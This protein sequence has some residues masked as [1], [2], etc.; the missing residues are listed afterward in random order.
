MRRRASAVPASLSADD[1]VRDQRLRAITEAAESF[2][3]ALALGIA[4]R[5]PVF[6]TTVSREL[7]QRIRGALRPYLESGEQMRPDFGSHAQLRVEG[8][9]L[10]VTR[11]LRVDVEFEDRSIREL[12]DGRLTPVP[13]RVVHLALRVELDPCVIRSCSIRLEASDPGG[14]DA[15]S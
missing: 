7:A 5:D 15:R 14:L 9:L 11:P 13:R 1:A 8:D 6:E 3:Y 12:A 4:G 2:T 10:D